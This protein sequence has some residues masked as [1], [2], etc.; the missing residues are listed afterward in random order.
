MNRIIV[1]YNKKFS[2]T[3]PSINEDLFIY[4]FQ[5]A[6]LFFSELNR[7]ERMNVRIFDRVVACHFMT[8]LRQHPGIQP[9]MQISTPIGLFGIDE[10][11]I[12]KIR[13]LYR[14]VRKN[15]AKS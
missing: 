10:L 13:K 14:G 4:R 2:A 11:A 8:V 15:N 12:M 1:D 3:E 6:P 5:D 9:S 7:K